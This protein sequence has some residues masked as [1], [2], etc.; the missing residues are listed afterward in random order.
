M[1]AQEVRMARQ[2]EALKVTSRKGNVRISNERASCCSPREEELGN[3]EPGV[4]TVQR[5]DREGQVDLTS[6]IEDA[7][8]GGR[9][10]VDQRRL[11]E[12][13]TKD[14]HHHRHKQWHSPLHD[15][16]LQ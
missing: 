6:I 16:P 14:S 15:G 5:S 2:L 3:D 8:G 12:S 9:S 13:C 4:E 11:P 10:D 1:I 7:P